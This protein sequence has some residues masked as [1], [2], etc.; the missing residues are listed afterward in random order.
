MGHMLGI[1][2]AKKTTWKKQ[3]HILYTAQC[4]SHSATFSWKRKVL[5]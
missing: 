2:T 1:N 5:L 3:T 4:Y